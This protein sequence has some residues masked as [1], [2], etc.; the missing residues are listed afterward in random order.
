M[1]AEKGLSNYDQKFTNVTSVVYDCSVRHGAALRF[2]TAP[3]RWIV[4][5]GWLAGV[6]HQQRAFRAARESA[7]L[8]MARFRRPSRPSEIFPASV[9]ARR[10]VRM[11]PDRCWP[12]IRRTSPTRTSTWPMCRCPLTRAI[13]SGNAGRNI[14]RGTA[15]ESVGSGDS[16]ELRAAVGGMPPAVPRG[17]FQPAEQDQLHGSE[18]R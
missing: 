18:H 2:Q 1:A 12:K 10:S 8:G 15:G 17:V 5:L 13:R 14:V 4:A 3:G 9:A 11:S 7:R 6:S 16:Q